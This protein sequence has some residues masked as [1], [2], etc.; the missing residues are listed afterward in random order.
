MPRTLPGALRLLA[1][2]LLLTASLSCSPPLEEEERV[3]IHGLGLELLDLLETP[4]EARWQEVQSRVAGIPPEERRPISASAWAV[5]LTPDHWT[6]RT[7]GALVVENDS[8]HELLPELH[9]VTY[10]PPDVRPRVV[11]HDGSERHIFELEPTEQLVELAPVPPRSSR[12]YLVGTFGTWQPGPQ[13]RRHLGVQI[14][15]LN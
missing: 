11:L 10:A 4:S 9:L 12:M 7:P 1:P 13:D 3:P 15:G 5:N 2:C 14:L 8:D 6:T